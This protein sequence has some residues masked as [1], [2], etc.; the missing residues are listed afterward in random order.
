M[1]YLSYHIIWI[2]VYI[3]FNS[4]YGIPEKLEDA[5]KSLKKALSIPFMGYY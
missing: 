2:G 4:L 5:E 3:T 1:G